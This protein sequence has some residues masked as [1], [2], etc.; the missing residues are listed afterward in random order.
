MGF[1]EEAE[2]LAAE[3]LHLGGDLL[4]EGVGVFLVV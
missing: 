1:C 4:E 2:V 3:G